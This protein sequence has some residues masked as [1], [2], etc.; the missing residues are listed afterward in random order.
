MNN[1]IAITPPMQ[2]Q[3]IKHSNKIVISSSSMVYIFVVTSNIYTQKRPLNFK[4][5][6][7]AEIQIKG[8]QKIANSIRL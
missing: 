1:I 3:P 5:K 2:K 4:S 7:S 8:W 6:S